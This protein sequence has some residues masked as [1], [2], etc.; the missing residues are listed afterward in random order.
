MTKTESKCTCGK[1]FII[2]SSGGQV[3]ADG[4][5]VY[6]KGYEGLWCSFRWEDCRRVVSDSV[7]GAEHGESIKIMDGIEGL[8]PEYSKLIEENMADLI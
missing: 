8:D 2:E 7:P 5:K 1:E 4:K 3:R 6:P